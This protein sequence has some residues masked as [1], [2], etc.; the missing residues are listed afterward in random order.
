MINLSS[1]GLS[2]TEAKVYQA[3]LTQPEWQ[4]SLLAK[5]V[6]ES[7]TNVYKILDNLVEFGLADKYDKRKK[8]HYRAT[9]PTRLLELAHQ[10]K[11]A[12]RQAEK[13]LELH[14]QELLH[15]YIKTHEQPGVRYFQGKQEIAQIFDE[16]EESKEEVVFVHTLAGT[17]LYG[18][19]AMRKLH[20]KA[21]KS[22]F[23]RRGL[24]PDSPRV[25]NDYDKK[26]K[27]VNLTR[28]WLAA[29]DYTA[30]VEWGAFEDKLYV[31]SFGQEALGMI[32]Q[33]QQIADGFKQLFNLLERGQKLLPN[34]SKLPKLAGK[35]S[36]H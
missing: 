33:S 25:A 21:A 15:E 17:E 16:I 30:P 29:D 13:E 11:Q 5:I 35:R 18:I 24:T 23:H 1:A 14:T 26:D 27:L 10:K 28:T 12:E 32:I 6:H 2:P 31:I 7:R 20:I 8:I 4:P 34:Y 22:N 9:N 36:S 3:L 19:E